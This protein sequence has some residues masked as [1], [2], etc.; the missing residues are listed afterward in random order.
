[1]IRSPPVHDSYH[2]QKL[3]SAVQIRSRYNKSKDNFTIRKFSS[4]DHPFLDQVDASVS[5]L[6]RAHLLRVPSAEPLGVFTS[7]F[8]V[9][10]TFI[11]ATTV[12]QVMHHACISAYPDPDHYLRRNMKCIVAHSNRATAAVCL[13]QG[14][15]QNDEIAFRLRWKPGS[16]PTY[17]RDCFQAVGDILQQELTGA[18][19][20]M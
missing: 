14:G 4:L 11:T 18:Y 10:F 7:S 19:R 1:M 13:Q 20:A 3:V 2:A 17:L 8:S 6:R 12:T 9:P 5:I 15:A 16:V